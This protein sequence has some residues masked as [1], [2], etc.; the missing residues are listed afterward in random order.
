[1][2]YAVIYPE[3]K[4]NHWIHLIPN[5][6]PF[7]WKNPYGYL[8]AITLQCMITGYIQF[9]FAN[10]LAI[11]ITVFFFI[12][13]VIKNIKSILGLIDQNAKPKES[14]LQTIKNFTIFIETHSDLKQ[15]SK[16]FLK[17][18]K[19]ASLQLIDM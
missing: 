1:M 6:F 11:P 9:N 17:F 4:T 7:D 3:P 10:L 12:I 14:D 18:I 2:Q 16:I 5:R 8:L 19:L 13:F 15:L